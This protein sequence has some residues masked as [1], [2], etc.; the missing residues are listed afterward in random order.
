MMVPATAPGWAAHN[1]FF[2]LLTFVLDLPSFRSGSSPAHS[3]RCRAFVIAC[4]S[5]ISLMRLHEREEAQYADHNEKS[6]GKSATGLLDS[7]LFR[8]GCVAVH[9]VKST[10]ALNPFVRLEIKESEPTNFEPP[11]VLISIAVWMIS[12]MSV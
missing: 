10:A 1:S 7:F 12:P 8:A 4:E 6:E 11:C 2:Q 9:L 5:R 3:D